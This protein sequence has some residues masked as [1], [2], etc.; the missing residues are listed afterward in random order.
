[1]TINKNEIKKQMIYELLFIAVIA[2][3]A[4]LI[5][6]IVCSGSIGES[7]ERIIF[8]EIPV[9]ENYVMEYD[10]RMFGVLTPVTQTDV[11]ISYNMSSLSCFIAGALI[12][13][14][15]VCPMLFASKKLLNKPLCDLKNNIR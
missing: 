12:I 4:A 8:P 15:S 5:V 10:S 7:F 1:M 11:D 9:G 13:F 6:S 3:M 14:C 2:F